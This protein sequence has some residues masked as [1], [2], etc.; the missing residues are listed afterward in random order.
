MTIKFVSRNLQ[1]R[2]LLNI[3]K[4]VGLSLALSSLLLILLYL[5]YE[6]SFDTYHSNSKN[7]YR[8]TTTSP[9]FLSGKHFARIYNSSYIP[10]MTESLSGIDNYV[11]LSPIRGGVMKL[12]DEFITID[13]AFQCDSTFFKVFDIDLLIGNP[14]HVLEGPG[15]MVLSKN[16]SERVF[17]G[18]NPI[19]QILSVPPGQFYGEPTNF[20]VQGVMED[21]PQ[22][23]HFHPDFITTPVDRTILNGWSWTYLLLN[24][25]ANPDQIESSFKEFYATQYE[26]PLDE[27]N[28][29]SHLQ[30]LTDIHLNSNK[31][32]EI[33]GNSNMS[34]IYS[35]SIAVFLLLFIALIN[36]ANLNIGMAGFSDKYLFVG[37]VFGATKRMQ[38][39][40]F[41]AESLVIALASIVLSSIVTA[42]ALILVQKWFALNLFEGNL[43]FI[44]AVATLF[45]LLAILAGILPLLRQFVSN[46]KSSLN[47]NSG[48]SFK[49]RGISKGLIVLQNTIAI[50]LIIAVFVVQRQTNFALNSS[51][52]V[53]NSSMV[54]F[55]HV[56]TSIQ[57]RFTEFKKELLKYNSIEAVSAM[58]EEPGGDANDM[59][60]FTMEGYV[61]DDN[62]E[63]D[64]WI[65]IFPCDYSFAS[66]FDLDFLAGS[67][68][69]ERNVDNEGSGE[70]IINE[71]AMHRLKHSHPNEI[72]GKEFGLTFG[73]GDIPIPSGKI[74]GVVENFHLSS[75]K[76]EVEP[77]VMFKREDLWLI[78]L[79]VSFNQ[80][81]QTEGLSD[82]E[83]V[84]TELFP[85]YP[86]QYEFVD[87]MY[88]DVYLTEILQAKLLSVFTFIALFICSM[89]LLGLSLLTTQRRIKEIGIRK[90]NGA[91]TASIIA[92]LNW[93]FLKW[94]ILSIVLASPLAYLAMNKWLDSFVYKTGLSWWIFAVAGLMALFIAFLTVSIQTWRTSRMN[95][96]KALRYE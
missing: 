88:E 22:N 68:F 73:N 32:R 93:D 57:Q 89:G 76:K 29:E 70:Y 6:L 40:Y 36:Y 5:K 58:M 85:E 9:D 23:S 10:E 74:I 51:M 59:F 77:L 38:M 15:S 84:W 92:M 96:I 54:C 62:E 75:I 45:S 90:V 63:T 71:S 13:R 65:G 19:G 14:E 83:T 48:G 52:G 12:E 95:P 30:L 34:V 27:M 47:I 11:R 33:E 25:N 91:E 49:R 7:T 53:E 44:L 87:S 66:I 50:A 61:T 60:R 86:F 2:P 37:K 31:T 20:V 18:A 4:I 72:I 3:I 80:G 56:H 17:K 21:F 46:L 24:E 78:N 35:F 79:V 8:F 16:F 42:L 67:N 28:M 82:L 69:S 43:L 41:L 81:L 64:D 26:I 55:N 1:K 94:I 39:K